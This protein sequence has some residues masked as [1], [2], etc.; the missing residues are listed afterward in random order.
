MAVAM[1]ENSLLL[2]SGLLPFCRSLCF[3]SALPRDGIE[4]LLRIDSTHARNSLVRSCIGISELFG[5]RYGQVNRYKGCPVLGIEVGGF[6]V[7]ECCSPESSRS[8][9]AVAV[10]RDVL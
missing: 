6:G 3:A 2:A 4:D 5:D 10:T 9:V 7:K 1:R 8:D